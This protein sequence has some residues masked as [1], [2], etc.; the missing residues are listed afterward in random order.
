[1]LDMIYA[2]VTYFYFESFDAAWKVKWSPCMCQV[3]P[4]TYLQT[5]NGTCTYDYNWYVL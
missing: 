4:H 3:A 2:G 1:M 5:C